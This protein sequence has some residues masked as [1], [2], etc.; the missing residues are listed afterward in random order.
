MTGISKKQEAIITFGNQWNRASSLEALANLRHE[1]IATIKN[2][3]AYL[4]SRGVKNLKKFPRSLTGRVDYTAVNK[5]LGVNYQAPV[6][7]HKKTATA[8]TV[9]T[10]EAETTAASIPS[11]VG[12]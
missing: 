9:R 4:R 5:A 11:S 2:R 12:V 7:T 3:A 1:K 10:P 6:K 8:E